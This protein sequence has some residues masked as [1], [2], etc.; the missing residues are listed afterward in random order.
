MCGCEL[1][2]VMAARVG[3][4]NFSYKK[5]FVADASNFFG[6]Q[7]PSVLDDCSLALCR[8]CCN[9][10]ELH[11]WLCTDLEH[12]VHLSR[13]SIQCH[14]RHHPHLLATPA[15]P[16]LCSGLC[17]LGLGGG[18]NTSKRNRHSL[19]RSLSWVAPHCVLLLTV[20]NNSHRTHSCC[21]QYDLQGTCTAVSSACITACTLPHSLL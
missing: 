11:P 1:R 3:R 17:C 18:R 10:D 8:C 16:H 19:T 13:H 6:I 4:F 5:T 2:Q 20:A 21:H 7:V 14:S 12:T 9:H 15:Q